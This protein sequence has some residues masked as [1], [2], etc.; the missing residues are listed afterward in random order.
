MADDRENPSPDDVPAFVDEPGTTD[1]ARDDDDP[2]GLLADAP[3]TET[4]KAQA[5]FDEDQPGPGV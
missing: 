4:G 3:D 1:Q 2:G 5:V